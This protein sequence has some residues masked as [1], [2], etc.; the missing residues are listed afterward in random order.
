MVDSVYDIPDLGR[1]PCDLQF[2]NVV[3]QGLVVFFKVIPN[4]GDLGVGQLERKETYDMMQRVGWSTDHARLLIWLPI[5]SLN[6]FVAGG[7]PGT[8]S[9][10]PSIAHFRSRRLG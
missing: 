7:V 10:A 5:S 3:F 6:H 9:P 8:I 2:V 4:P 1:G